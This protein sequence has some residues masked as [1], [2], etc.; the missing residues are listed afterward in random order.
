M[1]KIAAL[2]R[3]YMRLLLRKT[4][5]HEEC[6]I[7]SVLKSQ[8]CASCYRPERIFCDIERNVDLFCETLCETSEEGSA[9]CEMDSVLNDVGIKLRR[10]LLEYVYDAAFDACYRLV[11]AMRDFDSDGYRFDSKESDP[12]RWRFT[13]A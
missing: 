11:E 2:K 8:A 4:L 10:G 9:T 7:L 13:R 3:W 5:S 1:T 6:V 12:D